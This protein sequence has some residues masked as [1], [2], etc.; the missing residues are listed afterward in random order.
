MIYGSVAKGTDT[1]ASDIDLLIVSDTV[2]LGNVLEHSYNVERQLGRKVN[3]NCYTLAEFNKRRQETDS[4]VQR[5]LAQPIICLFGELHANHG[6]QKP[7][8]NR[9]VKT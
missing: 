1:A 5:V 9:T 3:P 4:F 2:G 6:A 7:G 8:K